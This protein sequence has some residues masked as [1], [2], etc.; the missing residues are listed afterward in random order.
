MVRRMMLSRRLF[1]AGLATLPPLTMLGTTT[2]ARQW[3]AG[4]AGVGQTWGLSYWSNTPLPA[5]MARRRIWPVP[6]AWHPE[7][8]WS[9]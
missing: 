2:G 5:V 3:Q 1:V 9:A 4:F 6:S 7:F 8:I